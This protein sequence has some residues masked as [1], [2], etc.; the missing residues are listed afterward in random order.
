M[1]YC[2]GSIVLMYDRMAS[3]IVLTFGRMASSIVLTFGRMALSIVY[4]T[5]SIVTVV[6]FT[7]DWQ[8]QQWGMVSL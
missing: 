1:S 3:S 7:W 5:Q 2:M 4:F 6:T 8:K